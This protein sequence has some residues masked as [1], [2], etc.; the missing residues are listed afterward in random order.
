[1]PPAQE[2]ALQLYA[3]GLEAYR[4]QFWGEGLRLFT[5]AL[6]VRPDDGP[7]RVMLTRCQMYQDA[8]PPDDWDG[9]FEQL[10]KA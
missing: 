5:Q 1:L 8:P 2:E 9:V 3:A 10:V 4:K 7:S 6:A